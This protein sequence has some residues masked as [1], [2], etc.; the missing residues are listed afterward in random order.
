MLIIALL[1]PEQLSHLC[2]TAPPH[3]V[4]RSLDVSRDV[5]TQVRGSCADALWFDP[6]WTG[7]AITAL[8]CRMAVPVLERQGSAVVVYCEVTLASLRAVTQLAQSG[9]S[10][11]SVFIRRFDDTTAAVRTWMT[12]ARLRPVAAAIIQ[13]LG[14]RLS[15][16]PN[17][18]QDA[19]TELFANPEC[20][21]TVADIAGSARIP[22]R[23]LDRWLARAGLPSALR[24]WHLARV[25]RSYALLQHATIG[26][27]ARRLGHSSEK[28]MSREIALVT[29][30]SPGRLRR[31]TDE[32]FAGLLARAFGL[33]RAG[34]I[35][36]REHQNSRHGPSADEVRT[37]I[38]KLRT[39]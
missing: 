14:S 12:E 20:Y 4:I 24:L 2:E 8:L 30:F 19:I 32:Q 26:T 10:R 13:L 1:A 35:P 17:A 18:G 33:A 36:A 9:C 11:L 22:R 23:T 16:L 6:S 34:E 3:V 39:G 15:S 38:G 28:L 27:V 7:P 37:P 25:V 21:K 29:G 31:F 5:I